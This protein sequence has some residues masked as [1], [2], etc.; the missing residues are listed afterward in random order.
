M[1]EQ[2]KQFETGSTPGEKVMTIAEMTTKYLEYY[3]NLDDKVVS[4]FNRIDSN[5]ERISTMGKMLS[6]SV[7]CSKKNHV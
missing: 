5:F 6:N 2:R 3:I 7:A 1:G 4:G